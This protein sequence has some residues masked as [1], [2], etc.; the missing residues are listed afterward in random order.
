MSSHVNPAIRGVHPL[1][2]G[3]SAFLDMHPFD[4]EDII[5]GAATTYHF[6]KI[7]VLNKFMVSRAG[8]SLLSHAVASCLVAHLGSAG[9]ETW[10]FYN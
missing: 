8:I 6:M 9:T 5:M 4:C 2:R 10:Y 1:H 3:G 7:E